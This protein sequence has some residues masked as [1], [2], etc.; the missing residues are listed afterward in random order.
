MGKRPERVAK[1]KVMKKN[2]SLRRKVSL[3]AER[4]R[5]PEVWRAIL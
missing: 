4:F 1:A 2:H 5:V 3:T